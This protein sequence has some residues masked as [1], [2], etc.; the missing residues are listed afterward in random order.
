MIIFILV[1]TLFNPEVSCIDGNP[2]E[3]MIVVS[4]QEASIIVYKKNNLYKKNIT[5][6]F[7][8]WKAQLYEVNI[9]NKIIKEIEIPKLNIE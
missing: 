1:L 3:Q 9:I 5:N 2:Q 4:L 6:Q 7:E 8:H